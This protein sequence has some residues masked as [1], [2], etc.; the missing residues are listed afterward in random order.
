MAN[1]THSDRVPQLITGRG[2]GNRKESSYRIKT[3][4]SADN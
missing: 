3:T 2:L 4:T 1:T